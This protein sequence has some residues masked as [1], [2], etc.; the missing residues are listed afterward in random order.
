MLIVYM[1]FTLKLMDVIIA[2]SI[3]GT[4]LRPI[5]SIVDALICHGVC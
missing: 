3:V 5:K 4:P 1:V 2:V